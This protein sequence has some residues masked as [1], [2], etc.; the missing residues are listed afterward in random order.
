MKNGQIFS[1]RERLRATETFKKLSTVAQKITLARNNV[2]HIN[3]GYNIAKAQ[4]I[5]KFCREYGF[6]SRNQELIKDLI[7]NE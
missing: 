1:F 6:N 5:D 4:G 3:N 7:E 2:K